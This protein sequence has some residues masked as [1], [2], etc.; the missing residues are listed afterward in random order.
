[1]VS[2]ETKDLAISNPLVV[3]LYVYKYKTSHIVKP[4]DCLG[5]HTFRPVDIQI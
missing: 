4:F 1:M 5:D 3:H 2:I